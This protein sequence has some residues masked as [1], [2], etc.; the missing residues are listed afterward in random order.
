MAKPK[1]SKSEMMHD[2]EDMPMKGKKKMPKKK[3]M[4][5]QKKKKAAK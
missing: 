3:D 4:P 5:M 1:K 2:E